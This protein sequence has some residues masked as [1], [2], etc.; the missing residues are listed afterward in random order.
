LFAFDSLAE[1]EKLAK[2]APGS[3]V[4][5]RLLMECEGAQWP[6]SKKFGCELEMAHDLLIHSARLGLQPFGVSFHVGSQQRDRQQWHLA[7]AKVARLFSA[8]K[9]AGI[10]LEMINLGGG[11]PVDYNSQAPQAE[12]YTD[13]I[14]EALN[15]YFDRHQPMTMIEP[16]RWLVA[17]AGLIQSEVVLIS[18]KAYT[19]DRRWI[20]LDIGKFGGLA[21]TMDECI[22]YQICTPKDRYPVAPVVIAGPTCDSADILYDRADYQLP[23]DLEIGDL[24]EIL[25]TGAYTTTYASVGFNGFPPLKAYYL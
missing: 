24:V 15:C 18:K 5:C 19:E 20:Y 1:L 7:I 3:R 21:E 23:I 12:V 13:A 10:N 22:K 14:T 2:F 4:Y 25:G 17:D 9:L 11:F 6:L 16:G 8:L